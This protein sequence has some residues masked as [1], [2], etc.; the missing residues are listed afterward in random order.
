M[1]GDW[2]PGGSEIIF[3]AKPPGEH[4]FELFRAT[5]DG[6]ATPVQLTSSASLNEELPTLSHRGDLLAYVARLPL[7]A[8]WVEEIVVA[9]AR[10]LATRHHFSLQPAQGGA[11]IGALG[12]W[13]D[14]GGLYVATQVPEVTAPS[15]HGKVGSSRS[16]STA[17]TD[18]SHRQPGLR[19]AAGRDL[20]SRT[21]L[22]P[23]ANLG[24]LQETAASD[25]ITAGSVVFTAA[26][27]PGGSQSD[28]GDR[29]LPER[30]RTRAE[31]PWSQTAADGAAF[32]HI[33]F[34]VSVFGAGPREVE[35]TACHYNALSARAYDQNGNVV[36]T[37][38]H[39]AGQGLLQTL[40]LGGG[41]IARIDVAGAEIGIREV[42]WR[43]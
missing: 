36:S 8:G 33:A 17:A 20:R 18:A 16:P 28:L 6:T 4:S 3:S 14:D 25:S 24:G 40:T 10:T 35:L 7:P 41:R 27:L 15:E 22:P 12:F 32:A 21:D 37:A 13:G 26:T 23:C 39:T 9:D 31:G 5:A 29:L 43:P 11:R 1:Q 2:A 30:R 38:S 34:P 42:C 19:F